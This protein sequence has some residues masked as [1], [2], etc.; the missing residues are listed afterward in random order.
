[1][2]SLLLIPLLCFSVARSPGQSE[3]REVVL[4]HG[5]MIRSA[6]GFPDN[7]AGK[8]PI[9]A[10][11]VM[12]SWHAPKP[13]DSIQ[14]NDSLN[15]GWAEVQADSAGWFDHPL[16]NGAYLYFELHVAKKEIAIL[17]PMGNSLS[18]VNGVPRTGNPYG[19]K[20]TWEPWETR[21]DYALLPVEL[22]PGKNWFLFHCARGRFKVS[23]A[24]RGSGVFLNTRDCTLPDIIEGKKYEGSGAVVVVNATERS[25][26]NLR[27]GSALE[28]NP[29][30]E[31]P[32]PII[33]PMSV[34]KVRI[35]LICSIPAAVGS[36]R[37]TIR[38]GSG[39]VV[40]DTAGVSVRVVRPSDARKVTFVSGIDSSIQYYA[41]LPASGDASPKSRAL[42]LSLHG[43]SVEA[44]NQANSYAP[45]TWAHIVCP[46]NRRPYG[47]NWEDWGRSDALEVLDLAR[48]QL[49][50]DES[51][52]YLTGHSMGGH[53]TYHLGSLFP[54]QFAA[55][56]PSAGWISFWTYRV[57]EKFDNPSPMRRMLM[58]PALASDTYALAC[59]FSGVG[60]YILHGSD[61]DNVPV[62]QSRAMSKHL[63]V[64]HKDYV[65]DEQPGV[66]HWWDKSDEPG[67]DCT[68]WPPMFDFFAR[69]ARPEN[70][71]LRE[72]H[73]A[74]PSPGVSSRYYWTSVDA[75]S[76]QWKISRVDLRLDPGTRRVAG[77]TENVR[78]M[79]LRLSGLMQ[80][81]PVV[82]DLDS[83]KIAVIPWPSDGD[84]HL[85][86]SAGLWHVS[87]LPSGAVKGPERS[88]TFRDAIRNNVAFVY[89]TNGSTQ[90]NFWAFAKARFDAER[91]WY[92]GNGSIEVLADTECTVSDIRERNVIVYGNA[93]TH[94]FWR[95]LLDN[96][97]VQVSAGEISVGGRVFK[98]EDISCIFVR[99]REG[100]DRLSVGVVSGTGLTGMRGT[101]RMPYLLPGIGFPDLLVSRASSYLRGEKSVLGAGFFGDDWSLEYGEFVWNDR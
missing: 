5:L 85:E 37:L 28:R 92:Q 52:I 39:N 34:R 82:I 2:R 43:A 9:E 77:K 47:F 23:L 25:L 101:N 16:L 97:P 19:M 36:Q 35:P 58:R 98:G 1:M 45:K 83:Q 10:A 88:G 31:I 3:T 73:F 13:G 95:T 59:N 56:G 12:G 22:H 42:I 75:Q 91:F 27:I 69:H 26:R 99:P 63:S 79:T 57:R 24:F 51:R 78:R 4:T 46:T 29:Y 72:I 70:E 14:Y 84:L 49:H 41:L 55:I 80:A 68:D 6:P 71:R 62:D 20:D 60:V 81:G 94:R 32:L 17:Q 74:T 11:L 40:M 30:A 50:I 44:I 8:D 96:S 64:F 21:F 48:N 89:G 54:D 100:S 61:D 18:Y 67:A 90:E 33:Q 53:G 66:G 87:G 7:I 76:E 15:G 65:Y 86:R 93:K 38:L